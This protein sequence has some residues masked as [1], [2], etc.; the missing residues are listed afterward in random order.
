M[1][2]ASV[3]RHIRRCG[4][5]SLTRRPS[6]DFVEPDVLDER[7]VLDESEQRGAR[8]HQ[9]AP[10]L[11]FVQAFE[12]GRESSPVVGERSLELSPLVGGA[13]VGHSTPSWLRKPRTFE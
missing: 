9:A 3:R 11:V 1:A 6:D 4:T 2:R 5:E 10:G 13:D 12:Q 7:E 8:R